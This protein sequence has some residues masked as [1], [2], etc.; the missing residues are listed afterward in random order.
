MTLYRAFTQFTHNTTS[1]EV[2][3]GCQSEV[4]SFP[5]SITLGVQRSSQ[6]LSN[7]Q[8]PADLSKHT[9]LEVLLQV[10]VQL[11]GAH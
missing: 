1:S 4:K 9:S 10:A 3:L 6:S 2:E 11:L 8:P 5:K 7:N